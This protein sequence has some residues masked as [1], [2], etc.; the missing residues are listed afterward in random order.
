MID[1]KLDKWRKDYNED[2]LK[3]PALCTYIRN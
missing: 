3:I 1:T 2:K